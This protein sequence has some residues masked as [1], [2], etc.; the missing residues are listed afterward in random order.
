M[1]GWGTLKNAIRLFVPFVGKL[2]WMQTRK[3]TPGHINASDAVNSCVTLE[4]RRCLPT[5]AHELHIKLMQRR[6]KCILMSIC[7][8]HYHMLHDYCST[9]LLFLSLA[10]NLLP[11][12]PLFLMLLPHQPQPNRKHEVIP[13]A[14]Q[15]TIEH[16]ITKSKLPQ[17]RLDSHCAKD[18]NHLVN[19]VNVD[20][21][22]QPSH[23]PNESQQKHESSC[24]V[25]S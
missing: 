21:K 16:C 3:T 2:V 9:S 17:I 15:M 12:C 6:Q 19:V 25:L 14:N 22:T 10:L 13:D 1:C 7:P 8:Q 11:M 23:L 5:R 4:V 20:A 24:P 18:P